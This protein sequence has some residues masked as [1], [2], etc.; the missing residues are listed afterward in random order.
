MRKI[1]LSA[2]PRCSNPTEI[3]GGDQGRTS[4]AVGRSRRVHAPRHRHRRH[5]GVHRRSLFNQIAVRPRSV[6]ARRLE[7]GCAIVAAAFGGSTSRVASDPVSAWLEDQIGVR[8]R[9]TRASSR[10]E[11]VLRRTGRT[12]RTTSRES[13][14]GSGTRLHPATGWRLPRSI[15]PPLHGQTGARAGVPGLS[16]CHRV[17][18][19]AAVVPGTATRTEALQPFHGREARPVPCATCSTSR[20]TPPGKAQFC[21]CKSRELITGLFQR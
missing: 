18:K 16:R 2:L 14:L 10:I 4:T 15:T 12:E 5:D 21:V 6:G 17:L 13:D 20:L 7:G 1:D 9:T 19:V 11:A 3:S 8:L